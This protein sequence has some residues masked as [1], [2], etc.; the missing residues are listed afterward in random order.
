[1]TEL[2]PPPFTSSLDARVPAENIVLSHYVA[3]LDQWICASESSDG[4]V[5]MGRA[6][7]EPQARRAAGLR[8][9]AHL[10]ARTKGEIGEAKPEDIIAA[11]HELDEELR[12]LESLIADYNGH[13]PLRL[14]KD[15]FLMQV[16]SAR[17]VLNS[18][19]DRP[20]LS[21]WILP[22]LLF[23]S[24]AFAEGAIGVYAEQAIEALTRFLQV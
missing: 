21:R 20:F 1:M 11:R 9:Y 19:A 10:Q 13:M 3:S 2:E 14:S 7:T 24:G 15:A 23:V 8:T 16:R 12:K 4:R 5:F 18:D 22:T 17:S 6:P